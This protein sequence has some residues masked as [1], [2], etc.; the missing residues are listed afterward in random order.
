M[1]I[2]SS[3]HY[4]FLKLNWERWG[5]EIVQE[6][7]GLSWIRLILIQFDSWHCI[8]S[9]EQYRK[10]YLSITYTL[11]TAWYGSQIKLFFCDLHHTILWPQGSYSKIYLLSYYDYVFQYF[12]SFYKY[13]FPVLR[14]NSVSSKFYFW[15]FPKYMKG[16]ETYWWSLTAPY[17]ACSASWCWKVICGLILVNEQNTCRGEYLQ[18]TRD[19]FCKCWS[20]A[21]QLLFWELP[22]N[23][24]GTT[25]TTLT[26]SIFFVAFFF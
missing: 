13:V 7:R 16:T 25:L 17:H 21:T 1:Y 5:K 10:W 11:S 18:L 2:L 8:W 20:I 15:S 23:R 3:A 19:P 6:L 14:K 9:L 4:F 22:T 12:L 24:C 26:F